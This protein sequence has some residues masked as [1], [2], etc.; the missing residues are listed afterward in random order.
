MSVSGRCVF[1]FS[2]LGAVGGASV[3]T[4]GCYEKHKYRW[5]GLVYL[6]VFGDR[7]RVNCVS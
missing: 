4:R 2:V 6:C 1:V 5:D 7:A 3:F